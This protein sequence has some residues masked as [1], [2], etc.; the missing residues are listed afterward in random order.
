MR[1]AFI[2]KFLLF[3]V[4]SVCGAIAQVDSQQQPDSQQQGDRS[5]PGMPVPRP[6]TGVSI[7]N[8]GVNTQGAS[9]A[10][11]ELLREEQQAQQD[12]AEE[13]KRIAEQEAEIRNLPPEPDIEF[14]YFVA[15][16]LG[17]PLQLF[18]HDLFHNMPSTFAPLDRVPVTP[19]YLIGPGDELLIH[20]WGQ[21][22]VNFRT[23]VDRTGSI[24]IPKVGA[25]SVAGVRYDQLEDHLRAA[26]SRVFKNFN[27]SVTLG[28]LRSIQVFMVGQVRR[29]GSYTVSSLSTLV[30]VLFAS[31]G[32]SKRGSMRNIVLKREGKEITR[33]DL[34]DLIVRGDKSK[35][36]QLLPG[37]VIYVP[38]VGNLVALAGSVNVPGIFELKDHETLNDVLAYAGGLTTT[39][40][41]QKVFF[42]RIDEHNNR[43]TAEFSLDAA[44]LKTPLRD[45][46]IVRFLHISPRF[47][48]AVTLRGNVAVPGR[49]PWHQG[50]RVKD[51]I[52]SREFL[53]TE[54]FWN[55]QNVLGINQNSTSFQSP[56]QQSAV[57]A[58]QQQQAAAQQ[59]Q[60][61]ALAGLP[62]PPAPP[63]PPQAPQ[64]PVVPNS[65]QPDT[66]GLSRAEAQRV[67]EEALKNQVRRSAAE[68]NWEY[69]VI[70]RMNPEDL[71]T[72]LLPF[73]LGKAIA[74][75]ERQNLILEPGDIVTIFSQADMQVPIGQ[76]SKFVRLEG[77]FHSAG[78]YQVQAGETLRHLIARVGGLTP[79]AYLYGAEFSRES[80]REDQQERLDQYVNELDRSIEQNAGAQRGLSPD[81]A[82]AERQAQEGQ[83]RLVDKL[84]Q[85]KAT[86]R[87]VLQLRPNAT[88]D[89]LPDLVL[90]DG[91]RFLVPFRPATVNV[92]GAVYNTNSF[93]YKP[94][95]TFGDYLKLS[96]GATKNGDKGR[97]FIIR[98]DGTTLSKYGHGFLANFDSTR[99]MAGDTIV[100]PEKLDK[101]AVLRGFK[102][103]TQII[104]Q[105]VLGAA[106][107]KVLF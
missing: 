41:G 28:R 61:A 24:Y 23:T 80:V 101:G 104:S 25:I 17:Y 16:T 8:L 3:S 95:H 32:I 56:E 99:L 10:D 94:G 57:Q 34:Y 74:G 15:G 73:N 67:T 35:D 27:I 26:I 72:H 60:A 5:I 71:T 83:R 55:R 40:S 77:E 97:S 42:D 75:D 70:Q 29:P 91:D 6:S 9:T 96:G 7:S 4:L 45:G 87:I 49:Y 36:V 31:G 78:V 12:A 100:V 98:A 82:L 47:D 54:T 105:F 89:D 44:G 106:A 13:R 20:A 85:V 58:A 69:A 19:D 48:N 88:P 22:D 66:S 1:K 38:P 86:G 43:R 39:A 51:L 53:I 103:W 11:R 18:G 90:E 52:P 92:L 59:Q 50:M 81:E 76:Q 21:I 37:D 46:D 84:R 102:D 68:I 65:Q 79:Q 33:F 93:I 62:N 2:L 107:A 63:P 30:N 14:Q 64:T